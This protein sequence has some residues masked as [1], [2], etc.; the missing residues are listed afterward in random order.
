MKNH[1]EPTTPLSNLS[2]TSDSKAS[3][4]VTKGSSNS[5]H[6]PI[7]TSSRQQQQ[8]ARTAIVY[9]TESNYRTYKTSESYAD[10]DA[11][12]FQTNLCQVDR[13]S[14]NLDSN[15][16]YVPIESVK[17]FLIDDVSASGS[18][19]DGAG[20]G[21]DSRLTLERSVRVASADQPIDGR[22]SATISNSTFSSNLER[23][24]FTGILK[25]AKN[26]TCT[27]DCFVHFTAITIL[28]K[29]IKRSF[30]RRVR[31]IYLYSSADRE[32]QSTAE[33]THRF[34]IKFNSK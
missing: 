34:F 30:I 2:L 14:T 23:S 25:F 26:G 33:S 10:E 3:G 32:T 24:Y 5:R 1:S 7:S 8:Q 20:K 16:E 21:K 22:F 11:D 12:L 27:I 13:I 28:Y 9:T 19:V 31:F 6:D 17:R 4:N 29:D 15:Q 18:H